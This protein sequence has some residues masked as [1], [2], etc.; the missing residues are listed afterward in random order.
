MRSS[1][2]IPVLCAVLPA[3]A[4]ADTPAV[5]SLM[6]QA[7]RAYIAGDFDT[8]KDVFN[9]VLQV[10]PHNTLAIQYLRNIRLREA[11][12]SPTPAK[13]PLEQLIL[14]QVEFKDATF[15]VALDF[16]KTAALKQGVTVSFVSQL[17]QPQMDH[18]ITLSLAQI[19]FLDA[20]RYACDLDHAIYKIERYA[21]VIMP[22][23][24]APVPSPGAQ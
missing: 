11:G 8:A 19:P 23:G 16:F 5:A 15:S 3:L 14:P 6:A 4:F 17:P 20:L 1:L 10:D 13:N 2:L 18:Q 12:M 9:Q 22:N 21:I 24:E 7:Q